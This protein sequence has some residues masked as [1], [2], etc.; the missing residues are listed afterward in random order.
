M[1]RI[2]HS[3][4]ARSCVNGISQSEQDIEMKAVV[5]CSWLICEQMISS[6]CVNYGASLYLDKTMGYSG[7]Y[8]GR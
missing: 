4:V 5:L 1:Y 8:I 3:V 2:C 6:R 7:S